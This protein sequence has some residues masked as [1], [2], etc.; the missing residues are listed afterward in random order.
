VRKKDATPSAAII[1]S[2]SVKCADTVAAQSSGY[3]AGKKIRGRKRHILTDTQGNLL[4]VVVT[5]AGV[6][7]RDAARVVFCVFSHLLLTLKI[8]FAGWRLRRE[9]RSLCQRGG[10]ALRTC[11]GLGALD[12]QTQRHSQGLR[13]TAQTLGR[14]THLR[15]AGQGARRLVRDHERNP[16]HHEAFV[17]IAMIGHSARHLTTLPQSALPL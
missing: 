15:L 4:G 11:D 3:D 9:T 10:Q 17:Y 8:I 12:H 13:R 1:D 16:R 5:P 14:G 2:Q 7:D 6:Q